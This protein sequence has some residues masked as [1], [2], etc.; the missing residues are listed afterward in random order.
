MPHKNFSVFAYAEHHPL[1][2][3]II[4]IVGGLIVLHVLRSRVQAQPNTATHGA[5]HHGSHHG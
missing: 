5:T 3:A 4:V 2:A 1:F